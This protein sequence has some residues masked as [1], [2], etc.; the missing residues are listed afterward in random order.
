MPDTY[1]IYRRLK[2]ARASDAI[3]REI[4]TIFGQM[5]EERLATR[6]DIREINLS[7]AILDKDL[8]AEIATS[9][10]ETLR[11]ILAMMIAQ[12]GLLFAAIKALT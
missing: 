10:A 11:W 9:R 4:A 5:A 7:I 1:Q 6:Q 3:S 2:R 12:T 8:K